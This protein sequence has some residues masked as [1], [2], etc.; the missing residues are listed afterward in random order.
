LAPDLG[1]QV[2]AGYVLITTHVK[3]L[4]NLPVVT[5]EAE[6][7]SLRSGTP[8]NVASAIKRLVNK[9][10]APDVAAWDIE[11]GP[12]S[13]EIVSRSLAVTQTRAAHACICEALRLL[14]LACKD[15]SGNYHFISPEPSETAQHRKQ[16]EVE[17]DFDFEAAGLDLVLAKIGED[18]KN[19]NLV[20]APALALCG[21]TLS[22]RPVD[23]KVKRAPIGS[24]LGLVL[25]DALGYVVKP[26]Y[27][28]ATTRE[29]AIQQGLALAAYR[30]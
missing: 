16:L 5:Y 4:Q 28:I 30:V 8:A 26:G 22:G 27:V 23:L 19:L 11:R 15:R 13:I 24:V 7:M 29:K 10:M 21:I 12:A 17:G 18:N 14:D 20:V 2:E 6:D 9:R 3:L 1:Y 25:G